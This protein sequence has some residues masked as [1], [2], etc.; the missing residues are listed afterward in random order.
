[1]FFSKLSVALYNFVSSFAPKIKLSFWGYLFTQVGQFFVKAVVG[2]I[3]LFYTICK[4]LLAFIDFL[5]YFLQRLIGL[6]YWLKSG[7]KTL[8]GAVKNDILFSFLYNDTVQKVF[9]A[10]VGLFVVLL[11]IFTIYAIIKQEW[12]FATGASFGTK[13]ENSKSTIIRNSIKAVAIVLIFPLILTVGIISSNAILASLVKALT[14]GNDSFGNQLFSIAAQSANKYRIYATAN[15]RRPITQTV[16]FKVKDGKVYT[17][18]EAGSYLNY[19]N[20]SSCTTYTVNTIFP[21]IDPSNESSFYGFCISLQLGEKD[22]SGEDPN[23]GATYFLVKC[24]NDYESKWGMYYYLR[25]ILGAKIMTSDN[26]IGASDILSHIGKHKIAGDSGNGKNPPG[27]INDRSFKNCSTAVAKKCCWT[28]WGYAMLYQSY[29]DYESSERTARLTSDNL[30]SLGLISISSAKAIY[31]SSIFAK[32]FDGGQIGLNPL[33][34]EYYVNADVIDF[35]CEQGVTLYIMDIT[36]P[37][38][39]WTGVTSKYVAT[40]E[41]SGSRSLNLTSNRAAFVCSYSEE[42]IDTEVGNVLYLAENQ[43]YDESQGSKFIYCWKETD[44]SGHAKYTPVLNGAQHTV[45]ELNNTYTF[46]SSYYTSNYDG[47]VVA[48]GVFDVSKENGWTGEPT[49]IKSSYGIDGKHTTKI[50]EKSAYYYDI[51]LAG[52]ITH[53]IGDPAILKVE[54]IITPTSMV[55]SANYS[56]YEIIKDSTETTKN[57]YKLKNNLGEFVEFSDNNLLEGNLTI[58]LSNG[59][60]AS[61]AGSKA[62]TTDGENYLFATSSDKYFGLQLNN[63]KTSFSLL[64]ITTGTGTNYTLSKSTESD[65]ITLLKVTYKVAFAK[66]GEEIG[67]ITDGGSVTLFPSEIESLGG[68]TFRTVDK[69]FITCEKGGKLTTYKYKPEFTAND[70]AESLVQIG[71]NNGNAVNIAQFNS[72]SAS[73]VNVYQ[74]EFYNY[75]TGAVGSNAVSSSLKQ[76]EKDETIHNATP[77]EDVEPF[78][79]VVNGGYTWNEDNSVQSSISDGTDI[80]IFYKDRNEAFDGTNAGTTSSSFQNVVDRIIL[81]FNTYYNVRTQN[82]FSDD[83]TMKAYYD[84]LEK[85]FVTNFYRDSLQGDG[86]LFDFC[87][88]PFSIFRIKWCLDVPGITRNYTVDTKY[89]NSSSAGITVADGIRFDYFFDYNISL[90]VFYA[91]QKIAYWIILIAAALIIKVLGNAIWGAI[92]RFYEITLYFI[93]MPAMASMYPIDNEGSRFKSAIISPL[94]GKILSVYGVILGLNFFFVL[95]RP[96]KSISQIFTQED[97]MTSGSYFLKHL[98]AIM[99]VKMLNNL[100]YILFVLVAFT[101]IDALPTVITGMVSAGTGAQVGEIKKE[102]ADTKAT[103]IK[104][105]K[106][107]GD[108]ISGRNLVE[109][110][111]KLVGTAVG[112]LPLGALFASA[113]KKGA[114]AVK[115]AKSKL[116]RGDQEAQDELNSGSGGAQESQRLDEGDEELEGAD[117]QEATTSGGGAAESGASAEPASTT[118]DNSVSDAVDSMSMEGASSGATSDSAEQ[119]AAG[120]TTGDSAE[121]SAA[122]ATTGD[123]AG[124]DD[125]IRSAVHE[126]KEELSGRGTSV[127]DAFNDASV[128]NDAKENDKNVL[129]NNAGSDAASRVVA[130]L[131][132]GGNID[133]ETKKN[134]I[135]ASLTDAEREKFNPD[136]DLSKYT[137]SSSLDGKNI[138]VSSADGTT[139]TL[140]KEA[141]EQFN[142]KILENA[143]ADQINAAIANAGEERSVGKMARNLAL[144]FDYSKG[145]EGLKSSIYGSQIF[146]KA[147]AD[148]RMKAEATLRYLEGLTDKEKESVFKKL[149]VNDLSSLKDPAEREKILGTIQSFRLSGNK[150]FIKDLDEKIATGSSDEAKKFNNFMAETIRDA[151]KDGKFKVTAWELADG[152]TR[153]KFEAERQARD[154]FI[155]NGGLLGGKTE[156][157]QAKILAA[158]AENAMSADKSGKLANAIMKAAVA[159]ANIDVSKLSDQEIASK[160]ATLT[161]EQKAAGVEK[162]GFKDVLVRAASNQIYSGN[163]T[164]GLL[165]GLDEN[166]IKFEKSS[167]FTDAERIYDA[168][169]SREEAEN[170]FDAIFNMFANGKMENKNAIIDRFVAEQ[171]GVSDSSS[172]EYIKASKAIQ[173]LGREKLNEIQ[174]K[175]GNFS[176]AELVLAYKKAE[177]L[178]LGKKAKDVNV[179]GQLLHATDD[180]NREI[181]A[182][183]QGKSDIFV[184]DYL[185]SDQKDNLIDQIMN[186]GFDAL[187][188]EKQENIEKTLGMTT[189]QAR[190]FAATLSFNQLVGLSSGKSLKDI[191]AEIKEGSD[192]ERQV[193]GIMRTQGDLIS[194]DSIK[195]EIYRGKDA[196]A[197]KFVANAIMD[198]FD[199]LTDA[200]KDTARSEA[201]KKYLEGKELASKDQLKGANFQKTLDGLLRDGKITTGELDDVSEEAIALANKKKYIAG[202]DNGK[203]AEFADSV[204]KDK[205]LNSKAESLFKRMTGKDLSSAD[206]TTIQQ[207]LMSKEFYNTL[208]KSDKKNLDKLKEDFNKAVKVE[209]QSGDL[210]ELIFKKISSETFAA[211]YDNAKLDNMGEDTELFEKI[212]RD[213]IRGMLNSG[214]ITPA[215]DTTSM[216]RQELTDFNFNKNLLQRQILA[217]GGNSSVILANIFNNSRFVNKAALRAEMA[218]YSG[219]EAE[220]IFALLNKH[221]DIKDQLIGFAAKDMSLIMSGDAAQKAKL[222]A[223]KG[224][225]ALYARIKQVATDN[226]LAVNGN[227]I[228]T[229]IEKASQGLEGGAFA[230]LLSKELQKKIDPSKVASEQAKEEFNRN[231]E[232]RRARSGSSPKYV[233]SF[234]E[235]NKNKDSIVSRVW[236]GFSKRLPEHSAKYDNWNALI[237]RQIAEI[238]KGAGDFAKLSR[239]ERLQKVKELE[240]KKI[241]YGK[242]ENFASMTVEEQNSWEDQQAINRK[243]AYSSK[244]YSK[245][246]NTL[247]RRSSPKNRTK[248]QFTEEYG[249]E[250]SYEGSS[251]D[252]RRQQRNIDY[253]NETK[254]RIDRFNASEPMRNKEL[255][256]GSNFENFAKS[257]LGD[258]GFEALQNKIKARLKK[259]KV[260]AESTDAGIQAKAREIREEEFAKKLNKDHI[261]AAKKVAKD[262]DTSVATYLSERGVDFGAVR[263]HSVAEKYTRQPSRVRRRYEKQYEDTGGEFDNKKAQRAQKKYER[264]AE[265][266]QSVEGQARINAENPEKLRAEINDFIKN[267]SGPAKDF[268]SELKKKFGDET[269]NA[270][271]DRLKNRLRGLSSGTPKPVSV[272]QRMIMSYL[273]SEVKKFNDRNKF[274]PSSYIPASNEANKQFIGKTLSGAKTQAEIKAHQENAEAMNRL[275]KMFNSQKDYLSAEQLKNNVFPNAL[276]TELFEKKFGKD[277]EKAGEDEAKRKQILERFLSEQLKRA[278]DIVRKDTFLQSE[279]YKLMN[280]NGVRVE[281]SR[282]EMRTSKT[283]LGALSSIDRTVYNNLVKESHSAQMRY[284]AEMTNQ[285]RIRE[286]LKLLRFMNY[287]DSKTRAE[288]RKLSQALDDSNVKLAQ[289]KYLVNQVNSR[290]VTMERSVIERIK[291]Q[292]ST[293]VVYNRKVSQPVTSQYEFKYTSGANAGKTVAKDSVDAAQVDRIVADYMKKFNSQIDNM[294]KSSLAQQSSEFRTIID[295]IRKKI[296]NDFKTSVDLTKATKQE[297][298]TLLAAYRGKNDRQ[299]KEFAAKLTDYITKLDRTKLEMS[300]R[301]DDLN[302]D[303]NKIKRI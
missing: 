26:D 36:S 132:D 12:K 52:G 259:E 234:E 1:M 56:T 3:S 39:D 16:T 227:N 97:I 148:E 238:K 44:S 9:R 152:E 66:N 215:V 22:E 194:A 127:Q 95:L 252:E 13:A 60:I 147:M 116:D 168:K 137:V 126:A 299:S 207:F 209:E 63:E 53:T 141:R 189:D 112:A 107:A 114:G 159:G 261:I 78:T 45:S 179:L 239:E 57:T 274:G 14:G 272:Q 250:F 17:I 140:D 260:D 255:D 48:R 7:P 82:R 122:G 231:E 171:L 134:A 153:Q 142:R 47:V 154:R 208:S 256:F 281:K 221:E 149:G 91:P 245:I 117:E 73:G 265:W 125:A 80:I 285:D 21:A 217:E 75:F 128:E 303:M 284:N 271:Y 196:D 202:L 213:V 193:D 88:K 67:D 144:T 298:K 23:S 288:I 135:L 69:M 294:F 113:G 102:G 15:K 76:W 103:A 228:E 173:G 174:K 123:S 71:G 162:S 131:I 121:Q 118:L 20:N 54:G 98:R 43:K 178:G 96:I 99:S 292:E 28:T 286:R 278:N 277:F 6:D 31:N 192:R 212:K 156:G 190:A 94:I 266:K 201:I 90:G 243:E 219:T 276:F 240:I 49:Y 205:D 216:T 198:N 8:G 83:D 293:T 108:T 257:Y 166:L 244:N 300:N 164:G 40:K 214:D 27:F 254:A 86:A 55:L 87:L 130:G 282:V 62:T 283:V 226:R 151:A 200:E 129:A 133:E 172:D 115:W 64:S 41:V 30:S 24:G 32:Y 241:V 70:G 301:F 139:R 104:S 197:M 111:G 157:D 248:E 74:V 183:M 61:Y 42:C 38:I 160:Y 187:S 203:L 35:I 110:T 211:V 199:L 146:D 287:K 225:D 279:K 84:N 258:N 268:E 158:I 235:F 89:F 297:L 181:L 206:E 138:V 46:K 275:V 119:S 184:K 50:S 290:K 100:V 34:A 175:Y 68:G 188:R 264:T 220:K 165:K 302:I 19:V 25:D 51:V 105:I 177:M 10:M 18:E 143:T 233:D 169:K 291:P 185:T 267:Y 295:N 204:M 237:D 180:Q 210:D 182:K 176:D 37:E 247:I 242:P 191:N 246:N 106:D 4:W 92:K 79:F 229:L 269:I 65:S 101:M 232:A 186:T 81:N 11:I 120:A 85:S 170:N 273:D 223:I 167:I 224:N 251:R 29:I 72:A 2:A 109:G 155:S 58:Q 195:A 270:I 124:Q 161:N 5:Q 230:A 236:H 296:N 163:G 289:L 93:A 262:K 77:I 249:S 136:D 280:L 150:N 59:E 263:Y 222:N 253:L 145:A 218:G 33:Q